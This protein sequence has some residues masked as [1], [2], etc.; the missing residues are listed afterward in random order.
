MRTY[1]RGWHKEGYTR[2]VLWVDGEPVTSITG[3]GGYYQIDGIHGSL[4]PESL[5]S[6]KFLAE[7]SYGTRARERGHTLRDRML[8]LTRRVLFAGTLLRGPNKLDA[9]LTLHP[10]AWQADPARRAIVAA[11]NVLD[12]VCD[13]NDTVGALG[14][15]AMRRPDLLPILIDYCDEHGTAAIASVARTLSNAVRITT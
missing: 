1:Y 10:A 12:Y 8:K 11:F 6:A 3:R 2:H 7:S 5:R 9:W 14:R 13:R 4:G 15:D